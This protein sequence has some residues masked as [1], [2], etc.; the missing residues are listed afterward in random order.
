MSN[1]YSPEF[2]PKVIVEYLADFEVAM[3]NPEDIDRPTFDSVCFIYGSL[4]TFLD[5]SR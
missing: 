1:Y 5:P 3:V 2:T 4:M